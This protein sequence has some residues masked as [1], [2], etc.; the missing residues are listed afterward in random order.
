MGCLQGSPSLFLFY[1][2]SRLSL[3][4]LGCTAILKAPNAS[5]PVIQVRACGPEK[6]SAGPRLRRDVHG[7]GRSTSSLRTVAGAFCFTAVRGTAA[8]EA[9]GRPQFSESGYYVYG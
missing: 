2:A 5:N 3:D 6:L 4:A 9:G 1:H 7:S 8:A